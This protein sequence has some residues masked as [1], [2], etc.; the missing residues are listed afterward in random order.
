MVVCI[1]C[2]GGCQCVLQNAVR[3][4]KSLPVGWSV[5]K[6]KEWLSMVIIKAMRVD[7]SLPV[8]VVVCICCIG[9]SQCVSQNAVRVD[10]SLPVGRWTV[11]HSGK[12][13]FSFVG[14]QKS[15]RGVMA[16]DR[17]EGSI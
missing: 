1:C 9:G 16:M 12:I 5:Y 2:I 13:P 17:G 4:D 11:C 14:R 15:T 3:V 8:G 7:K 10:K 6:C